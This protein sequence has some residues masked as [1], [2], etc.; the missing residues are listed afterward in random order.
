MSQDESLNRDEARASFKSGVGKARFAG[1]QKRIKKGLNLVHKVDAETYVAL[2]HCL[3][4][5][6]RSVVSC[7]ADFARPPKANDTGAEPQVLTG[8]LALT[9]VLSLV[10]PGTQ[11]DELGRYLNGALD[12]FWGIESEQHE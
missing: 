5:A 7:W 6:A 1:A 9:A 4:E 11:H 10:P 3:D 2:G 8:H 12:K